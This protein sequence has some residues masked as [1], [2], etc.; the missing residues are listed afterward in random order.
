MLRNPVLY[1]LLLFL[2]LAACTS[3]NR[4]GTDKSEK[5]ADL[6]L[7]MGVRYLEI[8]KTDV[9]LE[10]LEY[11][12]KLKP[13]NSATH[14]VLAV[15][16]EQIENYGKAR[17]HFEKSIELSPDNPSTINNYGRFLCI[18]GDYEK[19]MQYLSQAMSMALN[20]RKWY[21]FTNAGICEYNHGNKKSSEHYYREALQLQPAYAPALLEMIQVSYDNGKYMSSRAFIERY[22]GVAKHTA[23][24]LLLAMETE[25]ALG[26]QDEAV[27][28][29][30]QLLQ[31]FPASDEAREV[32]KTVQY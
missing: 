5:E 6:Y 22:Q 8:G 13:D 10:R 18:H 29:R 21:A 20:K 19:G 4:P 11:S 28:Y 17:I 23:R 32:R 2:L 26:N 1:F 16:Y 15:L 7:Q 31:K 12:L 27:E 25:N 30:Q 9:A 14:D 3:N 24:T